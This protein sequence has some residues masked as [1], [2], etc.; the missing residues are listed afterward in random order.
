MAAKILGRIR[1]GVESLFGR[2]SQEDPRQENPADSRDAWEGVLDYNQ[3]TCRVDATL[4]IRYVDRDG[5]K[6][7]RVID[8]RE[9]QVWDDSLAISA[10]CRLRNARRTFVT[11]RIVSCIDMETGE[12]ITNI[13]EFLIDRYRQSAHYSLDR[14]WADALD[15]M[16]TLLYFGKL[17]GALRSPKRVILRDFCH[18]MAGDPRLTDDDIDG[19]IQNIA[20][21]SLTSFRR[22]IGRLKD[23]PVILRVELF[24]C[25]VRMSLTSKTAY[26]AEDEALQYVYR[27]WN[28]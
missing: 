14:L 2:S 24:R 21:P 23:E 4:D 25:M 10:F 13:D 7:R 12:V 5:S 20:V 18:A 17:S 27:R 28:L 16:T 9:I 19:L 11:K 6:T 8:A 3:P 15:P 22:L 26:P 1:R